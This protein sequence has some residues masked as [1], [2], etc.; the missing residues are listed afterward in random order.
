VE[1]EQLFVHDRASDE[2][3]ITCTVHASPA[4]K[5]EWLRDGAVLTDRE[6][7][8][9]MERRGSRHTLLLPG[10][11]TGGRAGEYTCRASNTLGT[12][13]AT[14]EVGTPPPAVSFYSPELGLLGTRYLLA[15]A[16]VAP[17]APILQFRVDHHTRDENDLT[18][19]VVPAEAAA[20]GSYAGSLELTG[21]EP[22]AAYVAR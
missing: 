19:S 4:A 18:S 15:W 13:E 10:L 8:I 7:V 3:E 12:A 17:S 9:R 1:Q 2:L 16:V 22:G 5:V 20:D 21:L 14:A 6:R 11:T